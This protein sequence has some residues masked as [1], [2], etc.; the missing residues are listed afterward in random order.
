M[1]RL[2]YILDLTFHHRGDVDSR[3]NARD[4]NRV[5]AFAWSDSTVPIT[6]Q[7]EDFFVPLVSMAAARIRPCAR[8]IPGRTQRFPRESIR[9]VLCNVLLAVSLWLDTLLL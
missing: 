9:P 1:T 7:N 2:R 3:Y 6:C 5:S 4:C 8:A